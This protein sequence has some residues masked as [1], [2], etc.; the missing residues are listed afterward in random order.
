MTGYIIETNCE[1]EGR[2]AL[3]KKVRWIGI[4]KSAKEFIAVLPGH[5]PSVVDR[6]SAVLWSARSLGLSDGE[7]QEIKE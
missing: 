2:T 1:N 7:F 5:S 3:R 6:G 4:M